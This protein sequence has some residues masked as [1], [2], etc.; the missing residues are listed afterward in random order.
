METPK[1]QNE[2][3]FLSG[4]P[5]GFEALDKVTHGWQKSDLI[6]I[7]ARPAMGRSV[8]ALSMAKNI[9]VDYKIP[10]AL[11]SLE[12]SNVELV[13]R[14]IMNV[15]EIDIKKM[16]DGNLSK[17]E[18]ALVHDKRLAIHDEKSPLY[19]DD[20]PSYS[21]DELCSKARSFVLEKG[22][23][24]IIIDYFE[25]IRTPKGQFDDRALEVEYIA[26]RLKE[27]AVELNIP[28]V[29]GNS[30]KETTKNAPKIPR[31]SDFR[32][33]GIV[34]YADVLCY[35]YRPAYYHIYF[36]MRTGEDLRETADIIIAKQR[37]GISRTV[38]LRY[39]PEFSKF[40]MLLPQFL[41]RVTNNL[42]GKK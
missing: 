26:K 35:L 38:R 25:L 15:C 14:L 27:L 10:V 39:R 28:I 2:N 8:F 22:V 20:T 18:E 36:D 13:N 31:L 11:F 17:A 23:E 30:V 5:S 33:R 24:I 29:V 9:A 12:M 7:A 6:L 4:V 1:Q 42:G 16:R 34:N 37:S 3:E 40:E 21:V 19:I 32:Y 41:N